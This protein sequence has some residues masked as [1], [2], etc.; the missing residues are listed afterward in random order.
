[1]CKN[2]AVLLPLDWSLNHHLA[3]ALTAAFRYKRD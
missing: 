2:C 1:M 3:K